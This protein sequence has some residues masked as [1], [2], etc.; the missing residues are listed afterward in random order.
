MTRR[1]VI[2]YRESGL[3][4]KLQG[5]IEFERDNLAVADII[6]FEG[7]IPRI[8]IERKSLSDLSQ[9]IKDTRFREQKKRLLEYSQQISPPAKISY[10]IEGVFPSLSSKVS[11]LPVKTLYGAIINCIYRDKLDLYR[12]RDLNETADLLISL[13]YL[14]QTRCR[15]PP[16]V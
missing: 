5:R 11:N 1:I 14:S 6:L 15:I 7:N 12:T 4:N 10:W 16:S 9:S 2:D 3:I 8:L 13:G